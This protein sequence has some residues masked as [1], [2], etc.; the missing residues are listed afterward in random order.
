MR[1]YPVVKRMLDVVGAA[2]GLAVA[3]PVLAAAAV[4]IRSTSPGPVLYRA[5]RAGVGGRPFLML[6]LRT[7]VWNDGRSAAAITVGGDP[8]IT[9]AG[10]FLRRTKIDELPQ[11][12]NV[13]VGDMSLVG[14][15]PEDVGIV[16]RHYAPELRRLLCVR[17]GITGPGQLHYYLHQAEEAPPP[18]MDPERFYVEHQLGPKLA[19]DLHYVEHASLAYDARV[20]ARTVIAVTRK[21]RSDLAILLRTLA[22]PVR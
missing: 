10:A 14:P 17:P 5:R 20:L 4:A 15:R 9:R 8:R 11:L 2:L 21:L 19:L 1:A 6:K 22:G 13:V 16:E 12:V 3:A 18:G 7:M